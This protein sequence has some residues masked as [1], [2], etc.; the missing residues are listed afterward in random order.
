MNFRVASK[1]GQSRHA[2]VLFWRHPVKLATKEEITALH[3]LLKPHQREWVYISKANTTTYWTVQ[4]YKDLNLFFYLYTY[5]FD[6]RLIKQKVPLYP[7]FSITSSIF[8]SNLTSKFWWVLQLPGAIFGFQVLFS[9]QRGF[10]QNWCLWIKGKSDG[11]RVRSK[12]SF[13][14]IG[15]I[16]P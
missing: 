6:F 11:H 1:K 4:K 8:G 16:L 15:S 10:R 7:L 2:Y 13:P 12:K 14:L 5:I 3:G 9:A